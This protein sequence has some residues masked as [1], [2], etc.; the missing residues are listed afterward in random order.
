MD[1][2]RLSDVEIGRRKMLIALMIA[3]ENKPAAMQDLQALSEVYA[4][5]IPSTLIASSVAPWERKGWVQ[6]TAFLDGSVSAKMRPDAYGDALQ[7]VM[8]WFG[9]TTLQI[10]P[11]KEEVLSDID[12]P[13]DFPLLDG[14]KW[15]QFQADVTVTATPAADRS[16]TLDHD[17]TSLQAVHSELANAIELVRGA[18]DLPAREDVLASLG[19]AQRL[20]RR[21]ELNLTQLKVG[22]VMALEDARQLAAGWGKVAAI[23][24]VKAVVVDWIRKQVG[25]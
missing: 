18:N 14:W 13:R 8:D 4:L 9:A 10:N 5:G 17:D 19:Y 22:V 21:A 25:A 23:E 20:L 24:T 2:D 1:S 15:L 6:S 3:Y 11:R 16:V 7:F 12:A